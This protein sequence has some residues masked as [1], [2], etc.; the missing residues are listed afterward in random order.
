MG[1]AEDVWAPLAADIAPAALI[2]LITTPVCEMEGEVLKYG[3]G[4]FIYLNKYVHAK[5]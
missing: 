2:P 1:D 5:G 3:D 4:F